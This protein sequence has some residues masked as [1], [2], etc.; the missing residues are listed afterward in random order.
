MDSRT[1]S[2]CELL[3][4]QCLGSK[5]QVMVNYFNYLNYFQILCANTQE[6]DQKRI[7]TLRFFSYGQSPIIFQC[8]I[9]L[10]VSRDARCFEG[11]H[12]NVN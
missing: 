3:K 8:S 5:C 7:L 4:L 2:I 6:F 9:N 11:G 1:H 12:E 10:F